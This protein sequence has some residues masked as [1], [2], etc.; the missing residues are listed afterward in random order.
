M[1]QRFDRIAGF[2][3]ALATFFIDKPWIR[4]GGFASQNANQISLLRR[5]CKF[6]WQILS[7]KMWFKN[8]YIYPD[9]PACEIDFPKWHCNQRNLSSLSDWKT[10]VG[11][12]MR[13]YQLIGSAWT[14]K[15]LLVMAQDCHM[16]NHVFSYVALW[17]QHVSIVRQVYTIWNWILK[18]KIMRAWI[19]T[20]LYTNKP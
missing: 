9:S 8:S 7:Q 18:K 1:S 16:S 3:L 17:L 19:L 11:M 15:G 10:M 4:L 6:S 13:N 14:K 12:Q 2:R 5:T 20:V